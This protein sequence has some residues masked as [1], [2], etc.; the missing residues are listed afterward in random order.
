MSEQMNATLAAIVTCKNKDDIAKDLFKELLEAAIKYVSFRFY[1]N[2]FEQDK[3]NSQLKWRR[4]ALYKFKEKL[5]LYF[6]YAKSIS[7]LPIFEEILPI[8]EESEL[9]DFACFLVYELSMKQR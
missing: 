6:N 3:K 2:I 7:D 5:S 4:E 1:W 8:E 9:G